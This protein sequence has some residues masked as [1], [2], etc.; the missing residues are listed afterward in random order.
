VSTKNSFLLLIAVSKHCFKKY[1]LTL[2]LFLL[3]L[4]TLDLLLFHRYYY[5]FI[6]IFSIFLHCCNS[7]RTQITQPPVDTTVLLG[8]TA[9]LQ[10]RVSSDKNIDYTI[11]WFR[12]RQSTPITNNP[13]VSVKDDGT[14]E[15]NAFRPSD[16]GLY[17]CIVQSSAGNESRSA[18][19]DI[20]ELPFAPTNVRAQRIVDDLRV[21]N[22]SWTKGFDGNSPILKYIIQRR[23]VSE[24]GNLCT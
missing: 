17:T 15:I 5:Y 12:E 3:L 6:I 2:P 9:T 11:N 1:S 18:K 8:L 4:F 21:V 13:R 10:C 7:V 20:V 23:E 14:L 24:L 19:L 16:V 22:I